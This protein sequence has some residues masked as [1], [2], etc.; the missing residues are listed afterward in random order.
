MEES[1][2]R[3][4]K[5]K[6]QSIKAQLTDKSHTILAMCG[7]FVMWKRETHTA[8]HRRAFLRKVTGWELKNHSKSSM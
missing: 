2:R 8:T 7:F 5:I 4:T 6:E 1:T 3:K